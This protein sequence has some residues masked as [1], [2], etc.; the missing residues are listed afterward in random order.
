M[1]LEHFE[2]WRPLDIVWLGSTKEISQ[3]PSVD[4]PWLREEITG[5]YYS[6]CKPDTVHLIIKSLATKPKS[7]NHE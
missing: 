4:L 5:S 1:V 2:A 7:I 6:I 3:L